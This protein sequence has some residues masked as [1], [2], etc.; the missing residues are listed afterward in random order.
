MLSFS[1]SLLSISPFPLASMNPR[2]L[3][4]PD[5]VILD[6][7]GPHSL[8]STLFH[9]SLPQHPHLGVVPLP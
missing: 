6:L 1:V 2:L 4:V 5:F 8:T 9:F 7:P 3:Y